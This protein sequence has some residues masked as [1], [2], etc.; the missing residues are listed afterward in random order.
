MAIWG[1]KEAREADFFGNFDTMGPKVWGPLHASVL[2]LPL[3]CAYLQLSFL[4]GLKI[5]YVNLRV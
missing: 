2:N 1:T 3:G 5:G 4:L